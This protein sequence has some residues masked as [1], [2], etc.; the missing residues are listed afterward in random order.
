[1]EAIGTDYKFAVNAHDVVAIAVGY[2]RAVALE[3]VRL[4]VFGVV[5]HDALHAVT[6][7]VEI[8]R[9]LGLAVN[10]D[11]TATAVFVQVHAVHLAAVRNQEPVMNFTFFVHSLATLGF[12]HQFGKTVFQHTGTNATQHI[13]ATLPL[14]HHGFDALEV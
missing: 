4:H 11:R 8:A 6:R 10:H 12:T 9:Q 14:Q 7:F 13:F 5:D 3:F 1:M 2:V